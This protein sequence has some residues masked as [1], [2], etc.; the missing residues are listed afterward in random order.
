MQLNNYITSRKL[1]QSLLCTPI[2]TTLICD[3]FRT[4]LLASINCSQPFRHLNLSPSTYHQ[5][6]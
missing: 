1:I 2:Y 3:C 4:G 5:R 6:F